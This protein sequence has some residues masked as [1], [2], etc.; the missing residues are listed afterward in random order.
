MARNRNNV[1]KTTEP[2]AATEARVVRLGTDVQKWIAD[3]LR[4]TLDEYIEQGVPDHI[5]EL[6]KRF[7]D[8]NDEGK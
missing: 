8:P 7:D 1:I 4:E 3:R 2:E 5:A 6:I